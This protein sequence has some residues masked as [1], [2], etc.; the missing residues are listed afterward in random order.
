VPLTRGPLRGSETILVLADTRVRR[1][2]LAGVLRRYGYRVVAA[3][4]VVEAQRLAKGCQRIHLLLMDLFSAENHHF[5]LAQWFRA[6][7][8]KIKVLVASDAVWE[9]YFDLDISQQ[10]AL[11]AKPFTPVELARMVR[12]VLG[13]AAAA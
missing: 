3:S 6:T 8:P 12:R 1:G 11:L 9:L 4:D 5:Q 10:I 2:V 7:Y 13:R